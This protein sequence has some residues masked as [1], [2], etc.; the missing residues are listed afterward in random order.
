MDFHRITNETIAYL[1]IVMEENCEASIEDHGDYIEFHMTR[2]PSLSKVLDNDAAACKFYCDHCMGWVEPVM[3]AS[4]LYA[5][6]DMESRTEPHCTFRV[7]SG[8]TKATEFERKAKLLSKPY[9][10]AAAQPTES[11]S[12]TRGKK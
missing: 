1:R 5:V 2:C 11:G 9:D 7:F 8:K 3:D 10:T 4:G 6:M 12:A